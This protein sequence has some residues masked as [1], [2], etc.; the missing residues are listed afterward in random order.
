MLTILMIAFIGGL[1]VAKYLAIPWAMFFLFLSVLF[2]LPYPTHQSA[3]HLM[4]IPVLCFVYS[5][6]LYTGHKFGTLVILLIVAIMLV[7]SGLLYFGTSVFFLDAS[8]NIA[9]DVAALFLY[10]IL[11]AFGVS[12]KVRFSLVV[13]VGCVGFIIIIVDLIRAIIRDRK[14]R[15]LLIPSGIMLLLGVVPV[16]VAALVD[17]GSNSDQENIVWMLIIAM[18]VYF[19]I[20]GAIEKLLSH[21]FDTYSVVGCAPAIVPMMVAAAISLLAHQNTNVIYDSVLASSIR[22]FALKLN[23]GSRFDTLTYIYILPRWL[24]AFVRILMCGEAMFIVSSLLSRN[25]KTRV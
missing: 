20:L 2:L 23:S 24:G 13:L 1:V 14:I 12:H 5:H 15:R 9:A 6:V 17:A 25:E 18:A 4:F 22:E 8:S 7:L 21:C 10:G 16:V 3:V 11:R 19:A